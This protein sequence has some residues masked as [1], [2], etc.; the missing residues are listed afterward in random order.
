M[1]LE[2]QINKTLRAKHEAERA[3]HEP[4][5]KLSA[6]QLGKPLLDQVLKLIGVPPKPIDDYVLRLFERGNQVEAWVAEFLDVDETQKEVDYMGVIGF[7][8]AVKDNKPIEI[9][10]VKSS[11]YKWLKQQGAKWGHKLQAGLYALAMDSPTYQI[12]YV[13]ADDFR[14]FE[15]ELP[16]ADIK[17]DIIKIVNEVANQIKL[18]TLPVFK[19]REKWQ[20][21]PAY[22]DYPEWMSLTPELAMEKLKRS[23]P[24]AFKKLTKEVE[25]AKV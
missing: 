25:H 3:L 15:Y 9:K 20:E 23:Y 16:T 5:G 2:A 14:T 24:D 10:S 21:N 18:A 17:P 7:V 4:S 8:D 11:Q 1:T 6:S 19:P 13:T 22:S 12:L